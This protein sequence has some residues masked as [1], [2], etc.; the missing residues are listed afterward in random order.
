MT[1]QPVAA[2]GAELCEKES[3]EEKSEV[4]S[5]RLVRVVLRCVGLDAAGASVVVTARQF[6]VAAISRQLEHALHGSALVP[7]S[8][9]SAFARRRAVV[10]LPTPR[11]PVNRNAC[12]TRPAAMAACS[13]RVTWPCPTTSSNRCGRSRRAST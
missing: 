10:V 7:F 6:A 9:L 12:A 13:V 5:A 3:T 2:S 11:G 1:V 4:A 8:Q